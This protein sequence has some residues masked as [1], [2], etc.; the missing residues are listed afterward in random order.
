MAEGRN[1]KQLQDTAEKRV[2]GGKIDEKNNGYIVFV[3]NIQGISW[4]IGWWWGEEALLRPPPTPFYSCLSGQIFKDDVNGFPSTSDICFIQ[5][6]FVISLLRTGSE[7]IVDPHGFLTSWLFW[8]LT[9]TTGCR[10]PSPFLCSLRRQVEVIWTR[11]I[12]PLLPTAIGERYSQTR[13]K[14]IADVNS[15]YKRTCWTNSGCPLVN[16][17]LWDLDPSSS[18]EISNICEME[19]FRRIRNFNKMKAGSG[20]SNPFFTLVVH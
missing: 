7:Y 1:L 15:P 16:S 6:R 12:I 13:I 11:K 4:E 8:A 10:P 2:E 18:N 3:R 5:R 20:S 14:L 17:L 9:W 19:A